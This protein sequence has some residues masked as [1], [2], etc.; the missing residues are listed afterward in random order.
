MT[1]SPAH[2]HAIGDQGQEGAKSMGGAR[3]T[4]SWVAACVFLADVCPLGYLGHAVD[5]HF[6]RS[7]SMQP[8]RLIGDAEKTWD[9]P[10]PSHDVG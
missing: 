1:Q 2:A 7:D 4:T 9:R 6:M 3:V 10:F 8:G 5:D